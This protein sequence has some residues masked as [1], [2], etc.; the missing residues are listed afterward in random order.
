MDHDLSAL[1]DDNLLFDGFHASF[2]HDFTIQSSSD[3]ASARC[4]VSR[5]NPAGLPGCFRTSHPVGQVRRAS[6]CQTDFKHFR[7]AATRLERGCACPSVSRVHFSRPHLLGSKGA[8]PKGRIHGPLM[9]VTII[10]TVG[11]IAKPV[12]GPGR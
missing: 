4:L 11:E 5:N 12:Q 2:P 1:A 9:H 6:E 8:P 3:A 7:P 10:V